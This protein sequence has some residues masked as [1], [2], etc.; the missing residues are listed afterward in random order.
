MLS[1][2]STGEAT[3]VTGEGH[4]NL[5]SGLASLPDGRVITAGY[6]D[7]VRE[8]EG[9]SF[10]YT[11]RLLNVLMWKRKDNADK[12]NML[13]RA[14]VF[15]TG[16]QPKALA[17]TSD[18]TTFVVGTDAVEAVRNNQKVADFRPAAS[19][20]AIAAADSLIAIGFGVRSKRQSPLIPGG[21]LTPSNFIFFRIRKFGCMIGMAGRSRRLAY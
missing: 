15:S 14:S 19:P 16:S 6:D 4:T 7:R 1:Y 10:T 20:T 5:V 2:D 12:N 11:S 18:K 8:V 13:F 21:L 3:P 9:S 17:T